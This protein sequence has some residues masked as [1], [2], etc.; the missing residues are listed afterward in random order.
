MYVCK[1]FE[2][3]RGWELSLVP[4]K[5]TAKRRRDSGFLVEITTVW[6]TP[7]LVWSRVRL[8]GRIIRKLSQS[9][10]SS[11]VTFLRRDWPVPLYRGFDVAPAGAFTSDVRMEPQAPVTSDRRSSA[12][13][14]LNGCYK[15][16]LFSLSAVLT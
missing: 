15:E 12:R 14:H 8:D 9:E 11:T 4:K 2:D 1:N 6:T 10:H 7:T 5:I 13:Q 3:F 16:K